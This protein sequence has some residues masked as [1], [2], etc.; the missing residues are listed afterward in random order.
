MKWH[1][2]V[3]GPGHEADEHLHTSVLQDVLPTRT[4]LRRLASTVAVY[5]VAKAASPTA[6]R[7]T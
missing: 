6:I 7:T 3:W 2:K 5:R 4:G 1:P